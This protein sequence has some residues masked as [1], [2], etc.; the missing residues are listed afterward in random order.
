M[1]K[2]K[3]KMLASSVALCVLSASMVFSSGCGRKRPE[4]M[5]IALICKNTNVSFWED[6][7]TGAQDACD[8]MGYDM[9]YYC[10]N[11]DD[12]VESQIQFI[13]DAIT[14]KVDAIIIAPNS[15]TALNDALLKAD[16]AGIDIININS[17][18]T[19]EGVKS[20]ISSSNADGGAVAA[21]Q[22]ASLVNGQCK[23]G[24]VGNNAESANA[25][26]E[27]F[28]NEFISQ[29][30][31]KDRS[32]KMA[33]MFSGGQNA[34]LPEGTTNENG[35]AL[36]GP[37]GAPEGGIDG[38]IEK[39]KEYILE[40]VYVGNEED[41]IEASKKLLE[42]NKDI[43]V[44]FA[45]N[46]YTTVGICKAVQDLGLSND[47]VVVG[48]NADDDEITFIKN[49]VLDGTVVQNPYNQGYIGVRYAASIKD[50]TAVPKTLDTG[51]T[52]V[53]GSNINDEAV[54]ILLYPESF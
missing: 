53:S 33:Q 39:Y 19:Y 17:A 8:E 5:S 12:D 1:K 47:I 20:V 18:S 6:V 28:E 40:P 3:L 27:G 31:L 16:N 4:G 9:T 46:T 38:E 45:T 52:F 41:A 32:E 42:E 30:V 43:N 34:P 2:A 36:R 21:R 35:E 29:L 11:A 10:A 51:V 7:R 13:D 37:M 44:L 23:I 26:I 24:I 14:K 25:R 50:G 54:K 49:G 15:S 22:A 48:F